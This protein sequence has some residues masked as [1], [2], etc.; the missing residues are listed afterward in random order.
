MKEKL[1]NILEEIRPEIDFKRETN[2]VTNGMLDS[3]DIITIIAKICDEFEIQ[4]GFDQIKPENFNSV[5][6][7]LEMILRYKK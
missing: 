7:M 6:S 2:F 3:L 1:L 5:N 4:I